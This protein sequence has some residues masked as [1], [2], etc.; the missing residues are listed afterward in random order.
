MRNPQVG[1]L[2]FKELQ[3]ITNNTTLTITEQVEA[4]Y[5]LLSLSFVE[6]TRDEKVLFTTLFSRISFASQRFQ[7]SKQTRFFV[8]HFRIK[9]QQVFRSKKISETDLQNVYYPLG[10]KAVSESIAALFDV[11]I[12]TN[13]QKILPPKGFYKTAPVEVK[14]FRAKVRIVAL[15]DDEAN[16]QI[17]AQDQSLSLIHI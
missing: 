4:L 6:A 2:L 5:R 12:P 7:I 8:H 11:A 13:I 15:A 9:G 14:E 17:I 16:Q 1:T 10:L 3:K